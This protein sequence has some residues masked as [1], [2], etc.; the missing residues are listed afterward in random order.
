[1]ASDGSL[2]A[3]VFMVWTSDLLWCGGVDVFVC[4]WWFVCGFVVRL[5]LL[6]D[7]NSVDLAWLICV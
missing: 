6:S 1:M 5:L 7:V 4:G 2:G 3:L